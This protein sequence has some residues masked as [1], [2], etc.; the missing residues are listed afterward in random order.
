MRDS[1]LTIHQ[2]ENISWAVYKTFHESL[3]NIFCC[4]LLLSRHQLLRCPQSGVKVIC[5]LLW[6][7]HLSLTISQSL[8]AFIALQI[9]YKI[10]PDLY[11]YPRRAS[12]DGGVMRKCKAIHKIKCNKNF[13][14]KVQNH[15]LHLVVVGS[16]IKCNI[17]L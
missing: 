7:G 9:F 3:S 16:L 8:Q 1:Q 2:T 10:Y 14:V 15:Y 12:E 11:S 4:Y 5:H 13:I 6:R 17:T